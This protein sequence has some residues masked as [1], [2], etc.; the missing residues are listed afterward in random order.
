MV[1][2]CE[3]AAKSFELVVSKLDEATMSSQ[4]MSL[5]R[6]INSRSSGSSYLICSARF[7]HFEVADIREITPREARESIR[8]N[9]LLIK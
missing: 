7:G 2:W 4:A 9:V 8:R 3:D 1:Y 6:T 5:R